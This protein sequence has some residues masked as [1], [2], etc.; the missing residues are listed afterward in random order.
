M[1]NLFTKRGCFVNAQVLYIPGRNETAGWWKSA[2]TKQKRFVNAKNI[3]EYWVVSHCDRR[4]VKI[5][6]IHETL[7]CFVIYLFFKITVLANQNIIGTSIK[8]ESCCSTEGKKGGRLAWEL[9]SLKQCSLDKWKWFLLDLDIRQ[10][11]TGCSLWTLRF[12]HIIGI[13]DS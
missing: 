5:L 13:T 12:G 8:T 3:K 1:V 2:I 6:S 10:R 9:L 7:K 4:D 11:I